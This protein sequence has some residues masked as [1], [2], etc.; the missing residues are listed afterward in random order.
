[1]FKNQKPQLYSLIRF[2]I[3]LF[4]FSSTQA[5]SNESHKVNVLSWWGYLSI[6]GEINKLNKKCGVEVS[7]D[8]YYSNLDFLRRV[9]QGQSQYDIAIFS[10]TVYSGI[11]SD[12]N[13]PDSKLY[14]MTDNYNPN[15]SNHYTSQGFNHNVVYFALSLTG[16]LWNPEKISID[17][18]EPISNV[19]KSAK[20]FSVSLLDD[21]T[22]IEYLIRAHDDKNNNLQLNLENFN[23]LHQKSNVYITNDMQSKLIEKPDFAFAYIWSGDAIEALRAHPEYKFTVNQHASYVTED[24]L[25]ELNLREETV[26]VAKYM[27]SREFLSYIQE[28]TLYFSPY[29]DP[30]S[31]N[32]PLFF[33]IFNQ[34]LR[35]INQLEWIK[36]KASTDLSETDDRWEQIKLNM[37]LSKKNVR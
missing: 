13:I 29:L 5:I 14:E 10:N 31:K 2:L 6:P 33:E 4:G 9:K 37:D 24:L 1:M 19:F 8:T 16:F 26:C 3:V 15:V 34:F 30:P 21:P 20:D 28:N 7:F 36:P 35:K 12:I 22:E 32:N 27:S 11:S 25:A 23:D 18:Q 17:S